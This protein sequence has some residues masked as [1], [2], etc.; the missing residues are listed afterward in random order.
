MLPTIWTP[1]DRFSNVADNMASAPVGR[2]L[3]VVDNM[4]SG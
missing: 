4:D 2:F 3:N 1:V